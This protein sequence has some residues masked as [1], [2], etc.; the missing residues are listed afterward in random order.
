MPGC[1]VCAMWTLDAD[2]VKLYKSTCIFL[3]SD[4]SMSNQSWR[5]GCRR[6]QAELKL[7]GINPDVSNTPRV[8]DQLGLRRAASFKLAFPASRTKTEM[9]GSSE[10]LEASVNPAV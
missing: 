6:K 5:T 9:L 3:R 10:S 2:V 7:I 8:S 4:A 1:L